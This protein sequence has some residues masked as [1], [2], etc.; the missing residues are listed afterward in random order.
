MDIMFAGY[1]KKVVHTAGPTGAYVTLFVFIFHVVVFFI[2]DG[3]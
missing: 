3:S 2:L 1:T